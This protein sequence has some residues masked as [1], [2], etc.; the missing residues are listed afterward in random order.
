MEI[1]CVGGCQ[2]TLLEEQQSVMQR[3]AEERR[4]LTTEWTHFHA[5]DKL[6]REKEMDREGHIISIAQVHTHTHTLPLCL[7]EHEQSSKN[8]F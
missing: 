1:M 3:C 5:Q 6:R 4:K 8:L 2:S 7:Y